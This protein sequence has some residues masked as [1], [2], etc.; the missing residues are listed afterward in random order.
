MWHHRNHRNSGMNAPSAN[1]QQGAVAAGTQNKVSKIVL[2]DQEAVEI[3]LARH[4]RG[5]H[6]AAHLAGQFNVSAKAICDIWRRRTW[7]RATRHLWTPEEVQHH[8]RQLLC[9]VC[10]SLDVV[11]E[12]E[13]C[14]QC[15]KHIAKTMETTPAVEQTGA[16]SG[17]NSM[18]EPWSGDWD[19][20]PVEPILPEGCDLARAC[21]TSREEALKN[22]P[23]KQLYT[24]VEFDKAGWLIDDRMLAFF[25]A[26]SVDKPVLGTAAD[27]RAG[28][29]LEATSSRRMPRSA[30]ARFI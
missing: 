17:E 5:R 13:A 30:G 24:D 27:V 20:L 8:L 19:V 28:T 25:I 6:D 11:S 7:W 21:A 26:N 4:A 18:I 12:T 1:L 16:E 23:H 22:F 9:P 10:T 14:T 3:Y 29:E 2:T 15:A